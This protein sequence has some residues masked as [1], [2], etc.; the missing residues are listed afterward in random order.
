MKLAKIAM[1]AV[2]GSV[3]EERTSVKMFSQPFYN[4][5]SFPYFDAFSN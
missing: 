5:E 4:M 1:T 2:L 3:E